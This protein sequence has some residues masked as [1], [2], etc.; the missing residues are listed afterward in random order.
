M[1]YAVRKVKGGYKVIN[2]LTGESKG[3]SSSRKK[4]LAHIRAM[5][6]NENK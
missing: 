5:Y 2:K 4:A 3:V 6:A 1:P